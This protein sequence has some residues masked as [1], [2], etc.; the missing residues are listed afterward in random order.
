MLR[1]HYGRF[2][3]RIHWHRRTLEDPKRH[4]MI[5]MSSWLNRAMTPLVQGTRRT[6]YEEDCPSERNDK[7]RMTR[8]SSTTSL[9]QNNI[10]LCR[11]FNPRICKIR[12]R[13]YDIL[14]CGRFYSST[15]KE[16]Q[17]RLCP[18]RSTM[19]LGQW[20]VQTLESVSADFNLAKRWCLCGRIPKP[21]T[22]FQEA[23]QKTRRCP[24]R[25]I[26]LIRRLPSRRTLQDKT[27]P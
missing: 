15:C 19:H 4:D 1:I 7:F 2:A 25:G 17:T 12:T 5:R 6:S 18:S 16:R 24:G 22:R 8:S 10:N 26:P 27:M 3:M 9:P 13:C 21:E 23:F 11:R 20:K 14:R